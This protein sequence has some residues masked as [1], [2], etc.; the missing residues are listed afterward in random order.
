MS[1]LRLI[2]IEEDLGRPLSSCPCC[3]IL[4][5]PKVTFVFPLL[6]KQKDENEKNFVLNSESE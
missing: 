6:Q 2:T 3:A 1:E 5:I 4:I